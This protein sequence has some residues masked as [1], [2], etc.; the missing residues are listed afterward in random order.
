MRTCVSKSEIVAASC[1]PV[2]FARASGSMT[3]E[4]FRHIILFV[5]LLNHTWPATGVDASPAMTCITAFMIWFWTKSKLVRILRAM[6]F[7][8]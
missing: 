4:L 2:W 7:P 6:I 8:S 5:E 1:V 3:T